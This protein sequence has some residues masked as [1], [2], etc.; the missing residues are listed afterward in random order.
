MGQK[1]GGSYSIYKCVYCDGWHIAKDGGQQ[2]QKSKE[3]TIKGI[4]PTSKTLDVEKIL[5]TNIPDIHPVYG[6][7]RGRTLSSTVLCMASNKGIW[8][9]YHH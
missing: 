9:S 2:I 3:V 1:Y 5:A 7:D 4:V 8:Y 6:G